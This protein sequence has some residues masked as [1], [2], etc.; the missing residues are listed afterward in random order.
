MS[1]NVLGGRLWWVFMVGISVINLGAALRVEDKRV[2][3][4]EEEEEEDA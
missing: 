1:S 4:T 3:A 2:V